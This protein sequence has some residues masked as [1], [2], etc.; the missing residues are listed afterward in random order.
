M[1]FLHQGIE[2][3]W[4]KYWNENQVYKVADDFSKPK[5]YVLDMFPY[6]SGAGLHV[7]HPLGYIASD[8]V[9]RHKRMSGFN[10]LHPMGFDAFGLPAEQYA[11]Q[12]GIH[13][14]V[15]TAQNIQRYREQLDNIGF[16]YD[17]SR[18]V[19]TCDPNYYKW[20][21]WIFLKLYNSYY[22]TAEQKAKPIEEL[23]QQFERFG[24]QSIPAHHSEETIFDATAWNTKSRIEQEGILMNYRLAF[25]KTAYVNWCEALGTVLANDEI[26]DGV[27]ERGGH[28]VEKKPMMQW[29]LRITAYAERLLKDMETLEWSDS[30]KIMQSNWI[31][32]SIGAQI[33]FAVDDHP[34]SIEIFTTRPDTIFGASF[35]VLA[36][37]HPLVLS[38]TT[39][40]QKPAVEQYINHSNRKTERERQTDNKSVSGV[41]TGAYAI[42][43]FNQTKIPIW[44]ADYVLIEYGTGAIMAVPSNDK[45][46]QL[47]AKHFDLPIVQ[48]VDQSNFP[49]ADLE[50]KVGTMINSDFLNGKQVDQAITEILESLESKGIGKTRIQYKLRDANFSR[51]RYWGEPFPIYYDETGQTYQLSESELPLELPHLEQ[52]EP[53]K[54]AKSPLAS[55]TDWVNW[56]GFIRETDTM[57]GYAGSSW[58]F[59]RYM[60]PVNIEAFASKDKLNY[61]K[62]VDLYI[63]GT[64][65]AV[66]HLM[67]SR[68]WHKF[69]FDYG[70]VNT[71]EPFKKLVN[72][73]MI[74]GIIESLL[75]VKD[76]HPPVFI[77]LNLKTDYPDD[78]L[79]RIPVHI[80]YVS[81]YNTDH[82]HLS[83]EGILQFVKW[84]PEFAGSMFKNTEST[85]LLN[86]LTDDFKIHTLSETGKMSKRYHNVV[87]P[88]DVIATYGADCFRMYE[89]FLGPIDQAKPW[90]TKGIDGVSKFLRKFYN[91]FYDANDQF[92]LTDEPATPDELKIL[93]TCIKKVN[94]D[95][96]QLSFNTSVSAFMI[97]VNELKRLGCTKR[98]VLLSLAQLLAPFAPFITEEIWH[99]AGY[100]GSI[101]HCNYPQADE[102][103]LIKNEVN[104]PVSINGKKRFEWIV[105]KTMSQDELLKQVVELDEIKKWL[106]G[107]EIKKII[108]V[109]NR[110]INIVI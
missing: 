74:Q 29:A 57:P 99:T 61:W 4:K 100:S 110:M 48:V 36:P 31:G 72:Q 13:P 73:G 33:F 97:C 46:D 62:D 47:F 25:R 23:V 82:S 81:D 60:D 105:A 40:S 92:V 83:K 51:Q 80:D 64:E 41:F 2:D 16:N 45:R 26:K 68:F 43:P 103:H 53:G 107:Q 10:V 85:C 38:I 7:G 15:S 37:E 71:N 88:D 1:E 104:Y 30:L 87:N 27:S 14:S 77:D 11:I 98:D 69:L 76:S 35:M 49:T 21:Q 34:E 12:T 95:I 63:G 20:T 8:I 54:S 9:A 58:Y 28:P 42:H 90:D 50:D 70:F 84:R 106:E 56:N 52:I 102:T 78:Q 18:E 86:E 5:F 89:M 94:Q 79:A 6:P 109:P 55:A 101:H 24:N 19:I 44:I 108:I 17:W 67:Y 65:H 39:P 3:K 59:L 75:L 93:H 22:N 66:G 91:L 96:E 32:K